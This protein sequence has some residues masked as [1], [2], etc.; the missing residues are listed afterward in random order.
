MA[1]HGPRTDPAG[2]QRVGAQRE[3]GA[4]RCLQTGGGARVVPPSGSGLGRG[5]RPGREHERGAEDRW[6]HET[7]P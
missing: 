2:G 5:Q 4:G 1:P 7:R 3:P 6:G